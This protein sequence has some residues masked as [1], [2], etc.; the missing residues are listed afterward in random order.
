LVAANFSMLLN[1][2][3]GGTSNFI[4]GA[5]A[6]GISFVVSTV[7]TYLFGFSAE[8][9]EED[10]KAAELAAK[11]PH[12]KIPFLAGSASG[13]SWLLLFWALAALPAYLL[14]VRSFLNVAAPAY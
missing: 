8:E 9:L 11:R 12:E 6:C 4:N 3:P 1:Y 14:K 2:I 7:V 13:R 5:I 10:R